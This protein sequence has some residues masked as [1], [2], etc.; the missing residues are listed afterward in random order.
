MSVVGV[1]VVVV[2]A[3]FAAAALGAWLRGGGPQTDFKAVREEMQRMLT[4]Q[5]QGVAGQMTELSKAVTQ[6]L[7]EV[8]QE[9]EQGVHTT[10]QI[11]ADAQRDVSEQLR[12]SATVLTRLTEHLGEVQQS[13]KE[14]T[15][16]AQTMQAVLGGPKSRGVLGE[17]QLDMLL[18]DMLP[19][20]GYEFNHKF[21][22]GATATAVL[23]AGRKMV[24]IDA[25]FPMEA[26]NKVAKE[27]EAG[28]PEFAQ[29]V[30]QRVDQIAENFILPDEGTLDLALL[31]VPSESA[32]MEVMMTED[33]HGRLDDYCRHIR[34]LPVSPN[35]LHAYL[36]A[37]LVGLKGM[38]LEENAKRMMARLEAVKK[39]FDEF[40]QIYTTLGNQIE[41]AAQTH[42]AAGQSFERTWSALGTAVPE[43][44][45]DD[46]LMGVTP[47]ALLAM[48]HSDN[49][50]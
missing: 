14:L 42:I 13:G 47:E 34:V 20:S 2:M 19:R 43:G 1:V 9:L 4:T 38:E 26:C 7:S 49:G 21:S 23:H 27:G 35:S 10:S 8:R 3:V 24:A 39:Q 6:Q 46:T 44:S 29:A 17:T 30:R 36:S 40:R 48:S 28:R 11:T 16:A 31:F 25:D 18:A 41:Q 45:L 12:E 50:A 37:V 15:Q 22:S 5:A 32:F 33:E